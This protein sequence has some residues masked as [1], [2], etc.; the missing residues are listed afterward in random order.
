[1]TAAELA[2]PH[3][4]YEMSQL[5]AALALAAGGMYVFPVDHPE[6]P[7]CA[8]IGQGHNPK[9]CNERGKHPAVA[10][11]TAADINPK[12]IHMWWAGPPRNI[13]INC[14]KSG[15]VVIDED[16]LGAFKKYADEHGHKITPTMVVATAKGRH[17]YFVASADVQ[18]GNKEGALKDYNINVRSGNAYVVGPGS[19]H[20]TGVTYRI[21][22]ARPPALL[23]DWVVQAI[24]TKSNGQ[25][26]DDDGVV[27]DTVGDDFDR[28]EL[29]EVIKDHTRDT[30]LFQ[31]AS[32]LLARELPRGEAEILMRAAWQRCEQPPK[33]TSAYTVEQAL[34]KLDRYEPGRSEGYEK[35]RDQDAEPATFDSLVAKEAA[36]IR[37]REAAQR[38][39]RTEQRRDLGSLEPIRLTEFLA[40]PDEPTQYRIDSLWPTG[41]RIVLAAQFKAGK[42]TTVNN[43]VRSL[44]DSD[45]FLGRF[46]TTPARVALVD[47]EMDS[48]KVRQWLR[49]QQIRNTDNVHVV[50]LRGKVSAF[51][52]LDSKVRSEWA[53]R[54]RG[55]DVAIF[56][57]LRPI[58]DSLGLDENRDAGRL[59]TVLD[60]LLNEA[61]V[62]EG[63][64]VHHMGHSGERSRGDSRIIDWPDATWKLVRE[65][66]ELEGSP[67]YFSAYGRDV[68]RAESLLEYDPQTRRL[69]LRGGNRQDAANERLMP[70]LFE[71][72]A[73]NP[74]GMS[75]RQIE[76]ALVEAG[77]GRNE[78]RKAREY[79]VKRLY[80]VTSPGA[81]NAIIHR[82]NPDLPESVRQCATS[83][84]LVR[85]NTE[86]VCASAPIGG[87]HT[88]HTHSDAVSDPPVDLTD[89]G[90]AP[91]PNPVLAD[92][93]VQLDLISDLDAVKEVAPVARTNKR[94]KVGTCAGCG[95]RMTI[96]EDGQTT[97]PGCEV[98]Q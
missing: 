52:V 37:I 84:P 9:T 54:I 47:F 98:T 21:E 32:S 4:T 91:P 63:M 97:H 59:L 5:D 45:P 67:R 53:A 10:F 50:P 11:T 34:G 41:G 28:F 78:A 74:D 7:Q 80:L 38:K 12:M 75:G 90:H 33:A 1:M 92:G 64:L 24:K 65:N 72:L 18:L 55:T 79:A 17:Y 57:C 43:I 22:V 36:K 71:R 46:D 29:P 13:G 19:L 62:P 26:V 93:A 89:N 30:T 27:W 8:G 16:V 40:T 61:Q 15:L 83:A 66:P 69:T 87:A 68:F 42:T 85:R 88:Q 25:K 39:V 49:D 31:Y 56:D 76:D 95:E 35:G 23:P 94:Q 44:A 51:D 77:H 73:A 70:P 2:V 86:S 48:R 60:E 20:Q 82:I 14:G 81:K 96:T 58:L 3:I 6:L